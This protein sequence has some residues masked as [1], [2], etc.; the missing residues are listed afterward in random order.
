VLSLAMR[1]G[2]EFTDNLSWPGGRDIMSVSQAAPSEV[3]R[4]QERLN[5]LH[6][7]V[8]RLARL[9]A[10]QYAQLREPL[11]VSSRRANVCSQPA[12]CSDPLPFLSRLLDPQAVA[13]MRNV[14]EH[15]TM[16][17]ACDHLYDYFREP[18][19]MHGDRISSP[20]NQGMSS[21]YDAAMSQTPTA[22]EALALP[23]SPRMSTGLYDV[24]SQSVKALEEGCLSGFKRAR[25][26]SLDLEAADSLLLLSPA[27]L[28]GSD[29]SR[30]LSG[31]SACDMPTAAL[32]SVDH[33]FTSSHSGRDASLART[34]GSQSILDT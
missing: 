26:V 21:L 16:T 9:P 8:D 1:C 11:P 17:Q 32:E 19:C 31:I 10:H 20:W 24:H 22:A 23:P 13:G 12:L 15:G 5:Q 29:M 7:E 4:Y 6:T 14:A 33:S 27:F 18:L 25:S 2:N 3:S 28:P 30:S 34:G